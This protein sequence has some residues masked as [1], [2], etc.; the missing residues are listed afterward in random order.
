M[1]RLLVTFILVML[2]NCCT[3]E[4]ESLP[5]GMLLSGARVDLYV[6]ATGEVQAIAEGGTEAALFPSGHEFAYIRG[7]GCF[8][9]GENSCYTE[10]S[11]FEKSLDA[12]AAAPGRATFGPAEFFVRAVDVSQGGK[13]VF[14]AKPGP[15]PTVNWK[16]RM[17][18]YSANLDGSGIRQLTYNEAFD[19]D[20]V[21][22]PDGTRIAFSRRVRGRGQIFTM[23]SDGS[24]VVRVTHDPD[25]DRLPA[26]SPN[27]RRLVYLSQPAGHSGFVDREIYSVAAKG[28]RGCRLTDNEMSE[29]KAD[30]SPDG[31]SIAFLAP[32]GVWV[33]GADGSS[34]H[35]IL[36]NPPGFLPSYEDLDWGSLP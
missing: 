33:M 8:P 15:G 32:D 3:A 10:Y 24:D 26:W 6:P 25:R 19:N 7:V 9:S 13:L 23:R 5:G 1:T 31:R 34:P 4:A 30:Y 22:S 36:S 29:G 16:R 11:I 27:G 20:P 18:I 2:L 21:V 14:S 35:Q 12:D 17:E 28:G